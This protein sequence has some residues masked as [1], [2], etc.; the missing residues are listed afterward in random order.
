MTRSTKKAL[1]APALLIEDELA[2]AKARAAR[3]LAQKARSEADL[4]A[5]LERSQFTPGIID[6]TVAYL[7]SKGLIDDA[8]LAR[9]TVDS[10]L[11]KAPAGDALLLQRVEREG[12][13]Q[14]LAERAVSQTVRPE[15]ARAAAMARLIEG[16][17]PRELDK[18][19][20]W[21]RALG[22]MARRGF[23]EEESME[24][25]RRVMGPE[26]EA[27]DQPAQGPLF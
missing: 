22:A 20:R 11:R 18:T 12:V 3:L 21:R 10:T 8:Q 23:G 9:E 19:S 5:R 27:P 6:A 24:A 14:P 7:R 13:P 15:R 26:P 16:R 2:R 17:L 4:R 25:L 1:V